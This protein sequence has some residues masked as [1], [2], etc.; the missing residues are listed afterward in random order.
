[1]CSRD[2]SGGFPIYWP[3]GVRHGWRREPDLLL[4]QGTGE[5]MS[6]LP[7]LLVAIG[8]VPSGSHREGSST[9]TGHA[10]GPT[11]SSDEGRCN[12]GRAKG[13]GRSW[14][15]RLIN[16]RYREESRGETEVGRR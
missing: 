5:G 14:S 15:F 6:G 12:G 16:R 11:R 7:P 3:G 9:D 1:M 4:S 10:G 2:E 13:S 8:S